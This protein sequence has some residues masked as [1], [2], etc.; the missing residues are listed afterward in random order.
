M[1]QSPHFRGYTR[2]AGRAAERIDKPTRKR[3]QAAKTHLSRYIGQRLITVC[4][5]LDDSVTAEPIQKFGEISIRP[6]QIA[7][8]GSGA[9]A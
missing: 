8:Q 4:H 9:C 3:A 6:R 5:A 1:V 2:M 7:M